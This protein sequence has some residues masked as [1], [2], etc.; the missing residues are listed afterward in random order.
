MKYFYWLGAVA[1]VA[2]GIYFSTQFSVKPQ[3][4]SKLEFTQVVTPEEMGK[5]IFENLRRE[6]KAAP[7]VLLGVTPNQI[8]DLE[9][10]RGFLEAN[11]E[12]G[13]KYDLIVVESML[14]Y[15]EIFNNGMHLQTKEEL[16]RLVEGINKAREQGLRVAIIVPS[17]YAS[18]MIQGNPVYRLKEE[19]K[20]NVTSLSVSKFPLTRE[21]EA[22]FE[23]LCANGGA[24]DPAGTS[25]YG[26]MIREVA[27]KTYRKKFEANK[28]SGLVEQ[29]GAK[30][31]LILFN[32][33]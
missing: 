2:L 13:S 3:S 10:W 28:Y 6:I 19:Y 4:I 23:P 14:P 18:Q 30:D 24:V 21:Q 20:M 15:V 7:I 32:R 17:I 27:R 33:N 8:E 22:S 12:E 26:C 11:Q 31:Y 25:V 9:L 29:T 1:V 16:P 5:A